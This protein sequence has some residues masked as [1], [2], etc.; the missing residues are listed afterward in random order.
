ML[1]AFSLPGKWEGESPPHQRSITTKGQSPVLHKFSCYNPLKTSFL[2]A[3]CIHYTCTNIYSL[4][5]QFM[6]ILILIDVHYLQ[7]IV[8][9]FEKCSN[10]QNHSS[11]SSHHHINKIPSSKISYSS[12]LGGVSPILNTIWKT[13]V[14]DIK[15]YALNHGSSAIRAIQFFFQISFLVDCLPRH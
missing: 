12:P 6:L 15:W 4:Y 1:A 3:F 8:F 14:R 7:N 9:N 10:G 13:P 5:T 2:A 11:S